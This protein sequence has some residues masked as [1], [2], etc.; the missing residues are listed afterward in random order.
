VLSAALNGHPETD[1]QLVVLKNKKKYKVKVDDG[2]SGSDDDSSTD[3]GTVKFEGPDFTLNVS[4]TDDCDNEGTA[5]DI[6]VFEGGSSDDDS[7]SS[8]DDSGSGHKKKKGKK[9]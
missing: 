9:K 7:K 6:H 4:A 3:C 2:D 1:G 8:D 5:T